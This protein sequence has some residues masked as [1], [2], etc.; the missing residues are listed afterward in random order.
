MSS[1][2]QGASGLTFTIP[3]PTSSPTIGA[4]VRVAA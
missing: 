4:F 1:S 2:V 3:R